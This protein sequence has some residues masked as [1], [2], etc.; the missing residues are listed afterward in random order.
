MGMMLDCE[1][2]SQF[3]SRVEKERQ[4]ASGVVDAEYTVVPPVKELPSP[5]NIEH[6]N[7]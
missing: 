4:S 7:G 1:T 6:R 5:T 2:F 3:R